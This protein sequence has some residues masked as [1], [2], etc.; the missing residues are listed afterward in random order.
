MTDRVLRY[1]ADARPATPCLVLDLDRV[2]ENY[3]A[4]AEALP[5]ARVYYAVK[6]NPAPPVLERLVRLGAS[7]DVASVREVEMVLEAGA[8]PDRISFGNT[9]KKEA[10]IARAYALGV[11]LFAFDAEAELAKLDRAAP[12]A[13]VFCRILTTGEGAD[14]PL[15]RK[16]GCAP[17]MAYRL[18]LAASRTSVTPVGVSFHVGSQQ[19]DPGQWDAAVGHRRRPVP[20]PGVPRRRAEPRQ[21]RRRLPDRL[22]RGRARGGPLRRGDPRRGA[23]PLRQPR[24]EPDRRARP[25]PRR[26][27]RRAGD[28][29]RAHRREGRRGR[30]PLGLPRRRQVRRPRRDDGRGDPLPRRERPPRHA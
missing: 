6:A 21:R 27:R 11:R 29:G 23:A 24:A 28:R 13:S 20:P 17:E 16:F 22:P 18:L 8:T 1:L 9:I 15:S 4:L 30:P 26:R 2:E 19:K 12:G 25:Q 14:W 5:D 3:L 7:F 10:D